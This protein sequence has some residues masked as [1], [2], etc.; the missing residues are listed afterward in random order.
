MI[1]YKNISNCRI[2]KSE[3]IKIIFTLAEIPIPEVYNKNKKVALKKKRF[4]QTIV[5]CSNCKHIQIKETIN[6]KNLWKNYTYYS[7]Q[8]KAIESH[9][10]KLATKI[11]SNYNLK[12]NDL[13]VDIGSNDGTFL[14]MFKKKTK[15]LG[16]DPA[17]TVA[18]YAIK[19]NKIP[20]LINYFDKRAV[21][22]IEK[23]YKKPKIVLAFN[24]FAHTPSM[25]NFVKNVKK[26]LDTEGIFIFEAQYL[27]D[28]LQNNILGTF[29]HEHISHHSIYSLNKLF[30][31][32]NLK[33]L[34]IENINIQKGSILGFVTHEKN[35]IKP[36]TSVKKF[37]L[38]EKK[39]KIN[40]V[41]ILKNFY[42]NVKKNA[43]IAKKLT[44]NYKV[45]SGFGAARSGPTLLRNFKIENKINLILD[46]HPMKV[47]RYTP[48]SGIKILNS[49]NLLKLK[50]KLTI[51]LAYLHNKKIIKKNLKYIKSGGVFMILYPYPRLINNK[52]YRKYLGEKK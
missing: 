14:K 13:V 21:T 50:P 38:N 29:F 44:Q 47:N 26:I 1:E 33:F 5:R 51:I 16:I 25:I 31:S 32:F 23:K 9:F 27:G 11:I 24:V 43:D 48:S 35:K 37:I 39:N 28:I 19:K 20:T 17:K 46:N 22:K 49:S 2:C 15:V 7:N 6:Q 40:T 12:N 8:T 52:N 34:K 30:N 42:K 36:D 41:K 18:N 4:P 3:K 10:K 45:I